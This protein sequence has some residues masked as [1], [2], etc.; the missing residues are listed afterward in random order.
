MPYCALVMLLFWI[1][2]LSLSAPVLALLIV[3]LPEKTPNRVRSVPVI[4]V[5]VRLRFLIVSLVAPAP[6]PALSIQT[7]AELVPVLLFVIDRSRLVPPTVLEP[8]IVT[9]SAPFKTNI[10]EVLVPLKEE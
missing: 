1:V 2:L 6:V 9:Q 4:L 8:S 5:P 3:V 10:Q 7:T